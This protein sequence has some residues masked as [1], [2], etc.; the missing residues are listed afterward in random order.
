MS[1]NP[2]PIGGPA[3]SDDGRVKMRLMNQNEVIS[4]P[5]HI[6]R[7]HRSDLEGMISVQADIEL[8][9][10]PRIDEANQQRPDEANHAIS[11]RPDEAEEA[12]SPPGTIGNDRDIMSEHI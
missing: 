9:V 3:Y 12:S 11:E 5:G 8:S 4:Q 1:N 6:I 7:G 2:N 10:P